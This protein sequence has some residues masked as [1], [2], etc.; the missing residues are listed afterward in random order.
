MS[1]AR[2][3]WG[4]ILK[5]EDDL[6]NLQ[7]LANVLTTLGTHDDIV[8]RECIY[9]IGCFLHQMGVRLEQRFDDIRPVMLEAR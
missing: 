4:N 3:D 9:V 2:V 5:M 6:R 7:R 1:A 8:D